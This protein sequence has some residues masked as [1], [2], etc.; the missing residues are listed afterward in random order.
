ML[1]NNSHHSL[2]IFQNG[3]FVFANGAVAELTG[4]SI[5]EL[6]A[7]DDPIKLF[8]PDDRPAI[9]ANLRRRI[10]GDEVP[11]YS[12]YRI[13]RKDG[14][15]RWVEQ[16]A[17]ATKFRGQLAIHTSALDRTQEKH[18]MEARRQ[19]EEM[20]HILVKNLPNMAVLIFDHDLRYMIADGQALEEM[21]FTRNGLEGKT[22]WDVLPADRAS[23]LAPYYHTALEG[24]QTV[25]DWTV[26][27]RTYEIRTLPLKNL[28][29]VIIAGMFI[30]HDVTRH[31]PIAS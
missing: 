28:E 14:S 4:Y 8:H 11:A 18:A 15:I 3:R 1:V 12:E 17:F 27:N 20:Y 24:Q 19:L 25:F 30:I 7:L 31:K 22:I 29:G 21:G 9:Y 5:D 26:A 10:A 6:L 13:I 2:T 23:L 16:T